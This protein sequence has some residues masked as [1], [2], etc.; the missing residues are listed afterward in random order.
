MRNDTI[1]KALVNYLTLNE[2]KN[3]YGVVFKRDFFL[4]MVPLKIL[5]LTL[6]SCTVTTNDVSCYKFEFDKFNY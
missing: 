4:K 3:N 6:S 2:S 5:Y 1:Y